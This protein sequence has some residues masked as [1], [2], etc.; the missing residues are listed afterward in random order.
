MTSH[1]VSRAQL[2]ASGERLRERLGLPP[3]LHQDVAPGFSG[4][5]DE[6]VFGALWSRPGLELRERMIAVLSS[7]AALE[8][9]DM[10]CAY[11]RAALTCGVSATGVREIAIQAGLYTGF[12]AAEKNLTALNV[13]LGM[14]VAGD[15]EAAGP[16]ADADLLR[17]GIELME[18]MHGGRARTGYASGSGAPAALYDLAIRY[19]YGLLW[20]RPGLERR[21][22]L[23]V[24]MSVFGSLEQPAQ[25]VKFSTSAIADGLTVDEVREVVM[26]IAPYCGFPRAL[27]GL[28][29]IDGIEA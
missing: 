8:R 18:D 3:D 10:L 9:T 28:I 27:N 19:G 4:M 29:A 11:A 17:P 21:D 13:V 12:V 24:A 14:P 2:R 5:Y 20:N 16:P 23:I 22:R 6:L 1:D 7:L 15:P 25:L 26:Q